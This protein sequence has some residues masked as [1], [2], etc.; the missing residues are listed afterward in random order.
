VRGR[1][2]HRRLH[3][4]LHRQA[5]HRRRRLRRH[6]SAGLGLHD[7][8]AE[9]RGQALRRGQRLQRDLPARLRLHDLHPRL[10]REGL[11]RER[12]LRRHLPARLRLHRL[13]A[14]LRRETLRRER[15]LRRHL[16]G[17]LGMLHPELQRED[18]RDLRRLRGDLSAGLGLY[19]LHAELRGLLR[20][21][22]RLRRHLLRG[23]RGLLCGGH[24]GDLALRIQRPLGRPDLPGLPEG[25]V[26]HLPHQPDGLRDLLQ[27]LQHRLLC[28]LRLHLIGIG[29]ESYG[30]AS[31][32]R[33]PS[34]ARL[35]GAC[36]A[37]PRPTRGRQ[38]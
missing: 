9:L 8:H 38:R 36:S 29:H 31:G 34:A 13:H 4:E 16:Q 5:V 14:R 18:L 33:T 24:R 6:L 27:D 12:W 10:H 19:E 2:L 1:D 21:E 22:R 30:C 23:E 7:L 37:A 35:A 3:A 28:G 25:E 32:S 17:G 11:R 20:H 15:R 26:G